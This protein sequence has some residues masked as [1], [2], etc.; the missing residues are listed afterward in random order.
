MYTSTAFTIKPILAPTL[1]NSWPTSNLT[2]C[3]HV[4]QVYLDIDDNI[5]AI[6]GCNTQK[7]C[8]SGPP[9]HQMAHI[10]GQN[11]P[12]FNKPVYIDA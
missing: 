11:W 3:N 6:N 2:S 9:G 1:A 12:K 7:N 4:Q 5:Q 10:L 8:P